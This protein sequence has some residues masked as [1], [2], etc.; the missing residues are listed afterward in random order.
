[1]VYYFSSGSSKRQEKVTW[2]F[3]DKH[4]CL[5]DTV[6][7]ERFIVDLQNYHVLTRDQQE[8]VSRLIQV[9]EKF[10]KRAR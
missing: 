4:E 6:I 2:I 9:S 1:M 8:N 5:M 3:S 7:V 10:Y